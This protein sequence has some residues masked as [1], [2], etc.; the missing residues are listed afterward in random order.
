MEFRFLAKTS[1]KRIDSEKILGSSQNM[2][3][4]IVRSMECNSTITYVTQKAVKGYAIVEHLAHLPLPVFDEINLKFSDE[5]L[6]TIQDPR[7]L[8]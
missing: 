7:D 8:V 1:K 6:M 3:G 5:D 4:E 2:K